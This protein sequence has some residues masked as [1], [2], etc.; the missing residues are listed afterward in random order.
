MPAQERE[1]ATAVDGNR[2]D[3]VGLRSVSRRVAD[4][5]AQFAGGP[6]DV[7]ERGVQQAPGESGVARI[8]LV[9]ALLQHGRA[10][11]ELGCPQRCRQPR[12]AATDD[13]YVLV[14]HV[15]GRSESLR[16]VR[17]QDSLCM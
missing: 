17:P 14:A 9:V 11:A 7:V 12:D 2:L 4:D 13:D 3:Q 6:F 10:Q 5:C 1:Q 8:A 16:R 15:I